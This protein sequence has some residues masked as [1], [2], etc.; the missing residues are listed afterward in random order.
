MEPWMCIGDFNEVLTESEKM[1]RLTP[2]KIRKHNLM[3]TFQQTLEVC[4]LMDLGYIGPKYTWSNGQEGTALIK[5]RLDRGVSNMG[6]RNLF[7]EAELYVEATICSDHAPLMLHLW[8]PKRRTRRKARFA[9]EAGWELNEG[10]R[11][12]LNETWSR[13]YDGE[14]R[15]ARLNSK[16]EAC[17]HGL[18]GWKKSLENNG[19]QSIQKLQ[20]RLRN[21]QAR[22]DT[23]AQNEEKKVRLKLKNL[24]DSEEL[25]W[26]QRAKADWLKSGDR[27]TRFFHACASERKR[28]N[29]V[30]SIKDE[31]GNVWEN[32]RDVEEA[33][34][35]YFTTLFTQGPGG[36][37]SPCIQ[38]ISC[39]VTEEMNMELGKNFTPEEVEVALFQMEPLKAPGPDGLNAGF[40]QQNWPTMKEEV[41]HALLDVINNGSLP[42]ELN[43]THVVLIPKK[44][45]PTCVTEF[46]PISLCNVLYKLI[47][48]V[49]ANR[50]KKILPHLI[51][52]TQS[53][54]IPGRLITDN[55]LAAYETLHTMHTGMRGKKGFMAVKLDMSKAYDRVEWGF[56][57]AVMRRMG[58][59]E[60]WISLILMCVKTV[61]YSIIVNGNPCGLITPSRGIRQGD[62]ISPYLFILCAEA[63]SSM[64]KKASNDGSLTGVSTS[65]RGPTVSHLFFADDSLL[66]CRANMM[67][68]NKLSNILHCYEMA[69]GQKMNANKTSIFFSRNTTVAEKEQIQ[70]T[71]GIPIDQRYD[72]YLGLPALVGRSRM[73]AFR[74]IREKVW[75]RLQDWKNKFLSQAGKE[76]L[77]KAVVQAIPTY[78]M[79]VFLLPKALC[80]EINSLMAKFF[81]GHKENQHRIHWMNWSKMSWSKT[82]GGMGFRD[83]VCFNKAL[84]AKQVWRLW[85]YPESLIAKIVKAKYY[86]EC[87]VLEAPLGKKPSYAWRSIQGSIDL[88]NEGLVWR[89]GNGQ[90]IRIWKDRWLHSPTTF[91]VQ[92]APRV[93]HDDSTV[94]TL[95]DANIKWWNHT[96]LEQI[97]SKEEVRAIQSIPISVTN[98]ADVLIWRGTAKGTFSVRSAYHIQTEKERMDKAESSLR[99]RK[100][101]IWDKIWKL[102]IPQAEKHFL[103]R[104][105][106]ESLPTRD[107]LCH[108]KVITDPSCPICMKETETTFHAL[109]Q[110]SS[111]CD[112]WAAGG[113]VFQKSHFEGPEF[114]Q[115]VEG[116]FDRCDQTEFAL[117]V[118][119]TRRIWFRRNEVIHGGYFSHPNLI[120][121]Q[122]SQEDEHAQMII[123]KQRGHGPSVGE[124]PMTGWKA[125]PQDSFKI[126]WDA[127]MDQ[128]RGRVGLGV[129]IRDHQGRMWASKS[130]TVRG[131]MDPK[132]GETMAALMAVQFCQE[133]GFHNAHFEGDAKVVVE[134]INS[135]DMDDPPLILIIK[136]QF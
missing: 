13:E 35:D 83:F 72:T 27:N 112:V 85:K 104:A 99:L 26:R 105:C 21:L 68:W 113:R 3:Q 107:N 43:L 76:V 69:S 111:A 130:R 53:A 109:W 124:A 49:L 70:E 136:L 1:A 12:I 81:W 30:V 25:W 110:C 56:L 40:F 57:E 90:T 61:T 88:V 24:L 108:R 41:C 23:C 39:K 9:F 33:F 106:H 101:T 47:S 121:Q 20:G 16:L 80:K 98:Q 58:F 8:R 119:I 63:L 6:W 71:A 95:I 52:P 131:F 11:E 79:S 51:A 84:L 96:L 87:T 28:R 102:H 67:Q 103:W 17:I 128:K 89:V 19:Q 74:S 126:N 14:N 75:K 59:S 78:C 37:F 122:A 38:P 44:N 4:D 94:S 115:V 31:N 46:R 73:N 93:L 132:T 22:E 120:V 45:N 134:A 92:S 66:F 64:I 34:T 55:V 29:S 114:I 18:T 10:S 129:V 116:M 5:E 133:M 117:F 97:F 77:L 127:G 82:Q 42:P 15:W 7:P 48:K 32:S 100:S 2:G 125:P 54:F 65:K 60:R 123:V 86:P 118:G 62:P 135:G 91:R 36:D 50:L